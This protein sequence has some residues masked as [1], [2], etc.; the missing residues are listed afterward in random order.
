MRRTFVTIKEIS[1]ILFRLSLKNIN[2]KNK[3]ISY[4]KDNK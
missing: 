3:S 4:K 1:L 2:N